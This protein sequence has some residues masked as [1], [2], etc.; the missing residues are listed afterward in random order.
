MSRYLFIDL[1]KGIGII[2]V[3]I[4]HAI[5]VMDPGLYYTEYF[6]LFKKLTFSFVMHFFFMVSALFFR[7]SLENANYSN[8]TISNKIL[9][10][11]LKPYY[12]LSLLFLIINVFSPKSIGLPSL[13]EMIIGLTVMQSNPSIAP[14]LGLWFLFVLFVFSFCTFVFVRILK[15]NIYAIFALSILLKTFSLYFN[16]TYFF[17]M[18]KISSFYLFFMYGYLL[19]NQISSAKI[20]KK[21]IYVVSFFLSWIVIFSV[22]YFSLINNAY[23]DRTMLSFGIG[24]FFGT[25]FLIGFSYKIQ[26]IFPS[27][28][29]IKFLRSCGTNSLFIYVFHAPT[30]FILKKVLSLANM[31]IDFAGLLFIIAAGISLPLLYRKILSCNTRIYSILFGHN[32]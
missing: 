24:S 26:N 13:Q 6:N 31:T 27:N 29:L 17:S 9:S 2:L 16:D 1:A 14:S 32:P 3:V 21:N 10:S 11:R 4:G 5:A 23:I 8:L 22:Q 19:S 18:N 20:F 30:I 25:L 15:I 28:K 12:T 7:R